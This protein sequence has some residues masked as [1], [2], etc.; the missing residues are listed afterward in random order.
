[1]TGS[2]LL[3]IRLLLTIL[4]VAA[5]WRFGVRGVIALLLGVAA[6]LVLLK[7]RKARRNLQ[8]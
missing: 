6:V 5:A 4:V 2:A 1:M 3:L 8:D 7:G